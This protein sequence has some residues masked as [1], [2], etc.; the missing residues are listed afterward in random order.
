MLSV[1]ALH[2][3]GTLLERTL[4]QRRGCKAAAAGEAHGLTTELVR[5]A[6]VFNAI[7]STGPAVALI[8]T[9]VLDNTVPGTIEER[10]L[11]VWQHVYKDGEDWWDDDYANRV[12][13]RA[14]VHDVCV[15]YKHSQEV[16]AC[17]NHS[18]TSQ[19]GGHHALWRHS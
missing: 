11:H 1:T 8:I 17:V 7:F 13:S 10:G 9:M 14:L 12:C 18:C 5:C 3:F 16:R 4:S 2:S 15:E 19:A 6:D